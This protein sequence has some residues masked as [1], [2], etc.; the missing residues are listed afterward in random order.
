MSKNTFNSEIIFYADKIHVHRWP[1][2]STI[3]SESVEKRVDQDLN[4]HSKKI[5]VKIKDSQIKIDNY[6]FDKIKKVGVT[7]PLFKKE[8]TMVFEGQF[9]DYLAHIHI[10]TKTSNFLE[11]F[12]KL[13]SWKNQHFSDC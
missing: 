5:K 2:D 10:T 4:K 3:W 9:E 13:M 1:M 7:I 12:N 11:I 8:T 6:D